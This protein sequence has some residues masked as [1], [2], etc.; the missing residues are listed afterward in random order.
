MERLPAVVAVAE[1]PLHVPAVVAEPAEPVVFW[2][3]GVLTPGRFIDALPLKETPPMVRGVVSV[4]ADPVV[5]WFRVGIRAA[6]TVPDDIL[7]AFK[8]VSPE[9]SPEMDPL[10]FT[11]RGL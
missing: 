7:L 2:L 5:F 9:P 4:A 1:F 8:V 6:A 11:C 10:T 3:P